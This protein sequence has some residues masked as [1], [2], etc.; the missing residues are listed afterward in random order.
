MSIDKMDRRD[1]LSKIGL[2]G[3]A[4]SIGGAACGGGGAGAG[5]P[6]PSLS[7]AGQ[8]AAAMRKGP[9]VALCTIAF[10]DR[11]LDEVLKLAAD[12]GFDGVEP[13]GKPDHLPLTRTDDEVKAIQERIAGLGLKTSH[14]GSYVR[15][16]DGQDPAEKDRD[17]QRSVDITRLLDTDICRIWAG[18]KN[19]EL[20]NEA[21][22]KLMVEDGK[23]F[24]ARAEQAGVL[25]AIEMHGNSVTNKASAA[26]DL[27]NRVGSPSLKLNYQ[28]LGES[29]DPYE[30]ARLAGS[31]VVMVHAQNENPSGRGQSL[32]CEGA[33]DFRKVWEILHGQFGFAGYFEVEFVR[34]NTMDEKVAALKADYECLRGIA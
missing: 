22:W 31:H 1:F 7:A 15:L 10:Q 24:C 13:W 16:G 8:G 23:R 14:Y 2:S 5:A 21:D 25:L 26:V 6:A 9:K 19:S 4:L 27:I 12:V 32:I 34:G 3:L 18:L 30:R 28:I 20:L 17:M 29:E 11:P 33:V